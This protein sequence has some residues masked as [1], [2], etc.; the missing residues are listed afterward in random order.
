MAIL[1]QW[2]IEYGEA[3]WREAVAAHVSSGAFET[4]SP[5]VA[6]QFKEA[7]DWLGPWACS[8]WMGGWVD[9]WMGG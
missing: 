8:R 1:D 6:V 9:G 5:A 4:F 3:E 2:Y 7:L